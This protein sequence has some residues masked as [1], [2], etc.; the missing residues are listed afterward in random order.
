[1][2]KPPAD[3]R[4]I[5]EQSL[6]QYKTTMESLHTMNYIAVGLGK[7]EFTAELYKV[8][9]AYALQKQ[10]PPY[11]LAGNVLGLA[12][13]K[14]VPREKH[15]QLDGLKRP[16]V[17]LVEVQAVGT[18]SVGVAGIVGKSLAEEVEKDKLDTSITFEKVNGKNGKQVVDNT[19][20]LK[21]AV[22]AL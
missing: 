8:L 7:N 13:G 15:F 6:L 10:Q 5:P 19:G 1:P 2:E 11:V 16:L 17:D 22:D 3:R 12:D 14:P 9:A 20:V 21:Q 4:A 18:V